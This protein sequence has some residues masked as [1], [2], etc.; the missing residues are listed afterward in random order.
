MSFDN[1]VSCQLVCFALLLFLIFTLVN[2]FLIL[3]KKIPIFPFLWRK[4]HQGY[5]LF[6]VTWASLCLGA[7]RTAVRY[8]PHKCVPGKV[9]NEK[10]RKGAGV[11]GGG[12]AQR[13]CACVRAARGRG[14][15]RMPG[16][17]GRKLRRWK[18]LIP[19]G[20][21]L[22]RC[23][24]FVRCLLSIAVFSSSCPFPLLLIPLSK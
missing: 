11:G 19:S 5:I 6:S 2:G 4:A 13:L 3:K 17:A 9:L 16:H 8:S 14:G 24:P 21:F 1:V 23:H 15:V 18:C 22:S 10:Q 12:R 20:P 7:C